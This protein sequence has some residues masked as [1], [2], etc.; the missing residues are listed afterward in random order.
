MSAAPIRTLVAVDAD[1]DLAT[2]QSVL[3]VD[4]PVQVVSLVHGLEDGWT[5]LQEISSDA[6]VVSMPIRSRP[7][8]CRL[9]EGC[10]TCGKKASHRREQK[11]S[12]VRKGTRVR[13][14]DS[15]SGK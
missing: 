9:R 4:G 12:Q 8:S 5:T 14:I 1:V 11:N 7:A 10:P 15:L 2:V 3:P 6:L 13:A